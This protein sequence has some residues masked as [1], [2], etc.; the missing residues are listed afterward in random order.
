MF[1]QGI[2]SDPS[3][4]VRTG[5]ST[6]APPRQGAPVHRVAMVRGSSVLEKGCSL[7]QA[8]KDPGHPGNGRVAGKSAP[9]K[10]TKH[11]SK[12]AKMHPG[13][14]RAGVHPGNLRAK[15][16]DSVENS[17]G[18]PGP[19]GKSK[20]KSRAKMLMHFA[21]VAGRFATFSPLAS[22]GDLHA[23]RPV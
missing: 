9:E 18:S 17:G 1:P 20:G 12:R 4:F 15:E 5:F 22:S 7:F 10:G 21:L 2:G 11:T 19:S 8:S 16:L 14:A 13:K 3:G 6:R 23:F